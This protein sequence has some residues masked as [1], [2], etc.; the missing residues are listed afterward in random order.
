M[1]PKFTFFLLSKVYTGNLGD[2]NMYLGLLN[3][4]WPWHHLQYTKRSQLI[5]STVSRLFSRRG[6]FPLTS[7]WLLQVKKKVYIHIYIYIYSIEQHYINFYWVLLIFDLKT[8][9]ES[10]SSVRKN[11]ERTWCKR[12]NEKRTW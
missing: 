3:D 12:K 2:F 6:D 11:D 10:F 1:L 4:C 9:E 8:V 7:S 5:T